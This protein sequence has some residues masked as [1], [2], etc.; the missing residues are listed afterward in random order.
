MELI[1]KIDSC[2]NDT[3]FSLKNVGKSDSLIRGIFI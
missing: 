1:V 3:K 2:K